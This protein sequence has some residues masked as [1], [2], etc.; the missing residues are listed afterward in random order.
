L[1]IQQEICDGV[2]ELVWSFMNDL[3]NGDNPYAEARN[4]IQMWE[5]RAASICK[6]N[7]NILQK[8]KAIEQSGI[9]PKDALHIACAIESGC[10]YFITTDG[11][12][13]K[14]TIP[15]IVIINPARFITEE[16]DED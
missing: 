2:H 16:T 11:G 14:K 10:D 3:E 9:H 4:A 1:Q 6:T 13:T 8:G 7:L 15:G 12:L 5:R